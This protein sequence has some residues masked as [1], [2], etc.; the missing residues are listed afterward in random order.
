MIQ[1]ELALSLEDL[2]QNGFLKRKQAHTFIR[3]FFKKRIYK[4]STDFF[5][6]NLFYWL[7]KKFY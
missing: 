1:M 5:L 6:S 7:Q 2:H 4:Y 3:K